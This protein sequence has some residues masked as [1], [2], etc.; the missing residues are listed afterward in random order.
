MITAD[1][2]GRV[3]LEYLIEFED[4]KIKGFPRQT[5]EKEAS[6]LNGEYWMRFEKF[7]KKRT[8]PQ[9]RVQ[10][11]Y[12]TVIARHTG[13]T[14]AQIKGIAQAKFLVR[15]VVDENTGEIYPC[16]LDTSGL[17]TVEHNDFMEDLRTWALNTFD[18]TLPL[19]NE[20]PDSDATFQEDLKNF[21]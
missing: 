1:H 13:H 4:G 12:F 10:W 9:N 18:I 11:W 8:N 17:D 20:I 5:F 16:I 14:P 21:L 6:G 19:P 15:D 7:T 3:H 2:R